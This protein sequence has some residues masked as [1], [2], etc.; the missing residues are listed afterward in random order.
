MIAVA[1]SLFRFYTWWQALRRQPEAKAS[2]KFQ[3]VRER[4]RS[5]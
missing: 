5:L 4:S 2:G 1:A 3:A